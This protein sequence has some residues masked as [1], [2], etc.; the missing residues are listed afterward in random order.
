MNSRP[1]V[2]SGSTTL[3]QAPQTQPDRWQ[4]MED[5]EPR[6]AALGQASGRREAKVSVD[7][8]RA[9]DRYRLVMPYAS[10]L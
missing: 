1:D 10:R 2:E 8:L 5:R 4:S 6:P 3:A 9:T 7:P